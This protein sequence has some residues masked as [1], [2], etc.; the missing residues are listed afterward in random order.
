MSFGYLG[1]RA[2]T[3]DF[4]G[5]TPETFGKIIGILGNRLIQRVFFC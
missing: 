4:S 3:G 2:E 1:T 5:T